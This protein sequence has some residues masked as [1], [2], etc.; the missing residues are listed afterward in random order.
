MYL[1]QEW[2]RRH[3]QL[4]EERTAKVEFTLFKKLYI[5]FSYWIKLDQ[6]IYTMKPSPRTEIQKNT[7]P[8]ENLNPKKY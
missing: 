6:M 5:L 8:M 2:Y 1:H 7:A 4:K 3:F